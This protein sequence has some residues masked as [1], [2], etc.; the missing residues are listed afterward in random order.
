M[1]RADAATLTRSPRENALFAQACTGTNF[2]SV[3]PKFPVH[4][5]KRFIV[6][7]MTAGPA[8]EVKIGIGCALRRFV[9]TPLHCY[10][11]YV[12]RYDERR[13]SVYAT[14]M[15]ADANHTIDGYSGIRDQHIGIDLGAPVGTAVHV[16][17][18]GSI[19][20]FGWNPDDGDYG[21]V[22]VTR[23]AIEGIH[24]W[25]LFGHLS[26]SSVAFKRVGAAV[27]AGEQIG[28]VG[29][30]DEN[31]NWPPH[32]HF[33]VSLIEPATHDMP[34]VV[35]QAQRSQA[36]RDYPDPRYVLGPIY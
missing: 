18:D 4:D 27:R 14:D 26:A 17:L 32:L 23:H 22:V 36:L 9:K 31:G 8:P 10:Q 16:P 11:Y 29:G 35:S 13:P 21:H 6:H 15:F 1:T 25:L 28:A 5:K 20:S 7:D 34:G 30:R 3:M 19:H 33:Q 24:F 12:G 2:S